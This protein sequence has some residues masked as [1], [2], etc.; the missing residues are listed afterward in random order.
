MCASPRRTLAASLAVSAVAFLLY[1]A[2][3]LPGVDFGDTASLQSAGG[4]LEVTPRQS[5]PLYF[6]LGNLVVWSAG[7]EPSFGMNLASAIAGA[8][9]CGMVTA[10]AGMM[11]G[12]ALAALFSGL[13]LAGSYTFWSQSIIAEVYALHILMVAGSLAA[14]V[15]WGSKPESLPRLAVFFGAYALGFG[16]HL[17]MVLLGP[18]A[19]VYIAL[20]AGARA[21][22][23]PRVLAV[24]SLMAFLG[25]LQYGWNFLALWTVF[26]PPDSLG[27]GLRIF[28]FDVTKADWR[29]TLVLGV[30][31][32]GLSKRW[33]MY[34][35][36]LRQQVGVAGI[37]LAATG[38]AALGWHNRHLASLVIV[39][40]ATALAFAIT[41][42]VGDVHVFLVPSHLFVILAAGC[43]AATV[44]HALDRLTGTAAVPLTVG[45]ALLALPAWRIADAYPAVDRSSDRRA[46]EHL[47]RLTAGLSPEHSLLLADLNWQVQNGLDYYV[48]HLRPDLNV[49]RAGNRMLSLPVLIQE[50]RAHGR[51]VLLTSGSAGALRAAYGDLFAVEPDSRAPPIPLHQRL[52]HLE[53]GTAYVLA[54][55]QPYAWLPADAEEIRLVLA[56]LSGGR[57]GPPPEDVYMVVAG[58]TGQPA[59]LVH[60]S[61][62]P[63]RTSLRLAGLDMDIRME[64]WL[65]IDTMRR[66]GFGHVIVNGRRGLTLERGVSFVAL[67]PDGRPLLTTYAWG[68]YEPEAR[69]RITPAGMK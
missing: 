53:P 48:R 60:G 36:D 15:W 13:L 43:G 57:A 28:W 61:P 12:S 16:N 34:L 26:P 22:V 54:V 6:A 63:F 69:Y 51:E 47:E 56:Q 55:L 2:T 23:A 27:E 33:P 31:E 35:F 50:N 52:N 9:A 45:L 59:R 19:I 42:N 20:R 46:V 32:Y 17:M 58:E 4:S 66:A 1:R 10:L 30:D 21:L 44:I 3:L 8:L 65:P 38:V 62:R 39:G 37:A 14:L 25:A 24:A 40:Y 41:Y 5:Y 67:A 68:P 7:G 64:S 11:T 49:L 18:A 29:E